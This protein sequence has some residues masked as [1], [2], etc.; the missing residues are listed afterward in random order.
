MSP[1]ASVYVGDCIEQMEFMADDSIDAIVTDPPYGLEFMG[2]GWDGADGFRRSLNAAD[3]GRE[4]VFGRTSRTSPEYRAGALF[5]EWCEAWAV[6]AL[7]VLKPGGHMLAFG[8]TRTWHR[9]AVAIEDAG[10]EIRDSLAW[11]YGSGFPKGSI[12]A[13]GRGPNLKPAFEPV[14]LGR[15]PFRGTLAGNLAE[16]GTGALNIDTS[17]I[18]PGEP[19]P[20]GGNGQANHGGRFGG[21]GGT[22]G[23]RPLVEPHDRGRFPANV[24]L[25][26]HQATELDA[27]SGI[28]TSGANPKRRGVDGERSAYGDFAGQADAN[29]KRGVDKGGASRFFYVAKAPKSERPAYESPDGDRIAHPTVKP[30]ALM[31]YLVRL[32]TPVG[33]IVLDPFAG[34]G[35]TLEAAL[36]EGYDSIGIE[37]EPEYLPLIQQRIDRFN[38]RSAA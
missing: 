37:R 14:V 34:S 25:D 12:D 28:L 2:K 16:H 1:V 27:Q 17:R 7:R 22:A 23:A 9:L 5:Q 30:V 33:G 3:A 18:N 13:G 20:G 21:D 36:L 26:E 11:L 29:P 8:G 38:A 6:E 10:F 15:K 19:V 31:R 24:L 4:S 35:A 32:V